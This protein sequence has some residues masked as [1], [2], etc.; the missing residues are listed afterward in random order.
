MQRHRDPWNQGFSFLGFL[1]KRRESKTVQGDRG[2]NMGIHN[3]LHRPSI[4]NMLAMFCYII[5]TYSV[6]DFRNK[7]LFISFAE[8]MEMWPRK[9]ILFE[10]V[11]QFEFNLRPRSRLHCPHSKW[12]TL[13]VSIML[14]EHKPQGSNLN[15]KNVDDSSA[16][17]T[18]WEKS[19]CSTTVDGFFSVVS[20]KRVRDGILF[21]LSLWFILSV[22]DVVGTTRI[23][24]CPL[25][26]FFP[27]FPDGG[28]QVANEALH[29]VS[30]SLLP[31]DSP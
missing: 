7:E 29:E 1:K 17:A 2:T 30:N 26:L 11:V 16:L 14:R 15:I 3:H 31:Y 8:S 12:S 19:N 22:H 13:F 6:I 20:Q 27:S 25:P 21:F 9:A 24:S 4:I 28:H 18:F 5:W 10:S 23:I